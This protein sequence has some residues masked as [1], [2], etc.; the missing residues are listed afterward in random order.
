MRQ[1]KISGTS[2]WTPRPHPPLKKRRVS[3]TS[4]ILYG[5]AEGVVME[6]SFTLSHCEDKSR[7]PSRKELHD[8][9]FPGRILSLFIS[10]FTH[11]QSLRL[12]HPALLLLS[13]VLVEV[14]FSWSGG[15]LT[16]RFLTDGPA[17]PLCVQACASDKNN[18]S[19]ADLC[20]IISCSRRDNRIE[21]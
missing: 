7:T 12:C 15:G 16:W 11:T 6:S 18:T 5:D 13:L 20:S 2:L 17:V 1:L 21:N 3:L 14:G 19:A 10:S 9:R 8:H 4:A